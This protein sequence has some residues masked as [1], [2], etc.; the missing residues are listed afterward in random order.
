MRSTKHRI[1]HGARA[2]VLATPSPRSFAPLVAVAS[3]AWILVGCGSAP[4]RQLSRERPPYV[5]LVDGRDPMNPE[6]FLPSA[7]GSVYSSD[8]DLFRYYEAH[9]GH[10]LNL[11]QLS[12][13]GQNGAFGAGFLK[14]WRK[15]GTRPEFDM[16]TGV[17][18]G[19]LLATHAFL[20]TPADDAVLEEIFTKVTAEDIFWPVGL[21]SLLGGSPSLLHT[22]PLE[23]LL[24]KHITQNSWSGS[25]PRRTRGAAS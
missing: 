13:G 11:L 10:A 14:G 5:T 18:T 3:F 15:S 12:G 16:V 6:Q 7:A 17:S 24:E 20:G 1:H 8:Q 21:F 22:G 19:A 9:R 25:L 4:E 23:I 2:T